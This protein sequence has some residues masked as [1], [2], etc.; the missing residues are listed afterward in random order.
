MTSGYRPRPLKPYRP[1]PLK[2]YTPK[3]LKDYTPVP[4]KP[5]TPEPLKPYAPVPVGGRRKQPA[6]PPAEPFSTEECPHCGETIKLSTSGK[7]MVCRYCRN[8]VR[9]VPD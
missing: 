1:V 7:R 6:A 8:K 2:P 3:P 4:L 5:Y 9:W